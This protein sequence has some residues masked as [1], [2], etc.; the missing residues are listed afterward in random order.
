[1]MDK[2]HDA[3]V[4]LLFCV[5]TGIAFGCW[6]SSISAGIWIFLVT[7]LFEGAVW[8]FADILSKK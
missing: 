5:A 6:Q 3:F 4:T 1:M 2:D 7:T 8:K